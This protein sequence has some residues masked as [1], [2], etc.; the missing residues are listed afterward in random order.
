LQKRERKDCRNQWIK[1]STRTQSPESTNLGSEGL[2][3]TE[4]TITKLIWV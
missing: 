4:P 2:I 3:E 1:D